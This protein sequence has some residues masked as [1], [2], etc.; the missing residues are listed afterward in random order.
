MRRLFLKVLLG[1]SAPV[2]RLLAQ[3]ETSAKSL[4]TDELKK[5]AESKEKFFFLDVRETKELE[6]LGTMKG[7]VHIPLSEVEKRMDEI[8]RDRL[9]VL[10]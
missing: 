4:S 1:A 7:Y 5:L 3:S 2:F 9:V 8:P 10:A 6:E